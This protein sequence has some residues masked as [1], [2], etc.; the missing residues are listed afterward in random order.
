MSELE[1]ILK[2][3]EKQVK[4]WFNTLAKTGQKPSD[5]VVALYDLRDE[6]QKLREALRT[7]YS[8]LDEKR[9]AFLVPHDEDL[10]AVL[11]ALKGTE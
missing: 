10:E 8:R 7:A 3:G 2:A 1:A 4:Q 11:A 6:N 9:R 5:L